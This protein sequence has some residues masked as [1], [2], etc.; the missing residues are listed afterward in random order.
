MAFCRNC[1][2]EILAGARFCS[3]CGTPDSVVAVY[4]Y[5]QPPRKPSPKIPCRGLGIASMIVGIVGVAYTACMFLVSIMVFAM[6]QDY[7]DILPMVIITGF[8]GA[9]SLVSLVMSIAAILRGNSTGQAKTGLITSIIGII[10]TITTFMI[11]M[12]FM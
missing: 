11:C 5:A 1:G 12:P 8:F 4:A 7:D 10:C 6:E 3:N 2:Q 9:M